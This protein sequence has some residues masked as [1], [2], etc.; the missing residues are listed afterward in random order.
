[1]VGC[2][3]ILYIIYLRVSYTYFISFTLSFYLIL[4]YTYTK[5]YILTYCEA[6]GLSLFE[7]QSFNIHVFVDEPDDGPNTGRNLLLSL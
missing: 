3:F 4:F 2:G 6:K 5:L 1:M 7:E